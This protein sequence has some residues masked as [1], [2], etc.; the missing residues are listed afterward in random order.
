MVMTMESQAFI[1]VWRLPH[2]RSCDQYNRKY[3]QTLS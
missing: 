2:L 3:N 1:Y